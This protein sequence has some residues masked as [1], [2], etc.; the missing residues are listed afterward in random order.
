MNMS[1]DV[2]HLVDL[3][4]LAWKPLKAERKK[5]KAKL[6]FKLLNKM[7]PKS[8]TELF[9]FKS[10]MSNYE[11]R[12]IKSTLCLS[13]PRTNCM[14][15]SFMFDGHTFGTLYQNVSLYFFLYFIF[16]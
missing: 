16:L 9:T 11:L 3:D 2:D 7:D 14:K 15:K 13:Q 10:E 8:L 6:M 12:D 4:A 1:N 5:A